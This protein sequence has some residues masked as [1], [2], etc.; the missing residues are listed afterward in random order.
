MFSS[1]QSTS[2]YC[3]LTKDSRTFES[4][5]WRAWDLQF[6][7]APEPLE[8]LQVIKRK[9]ATSK[10][11]LPELS[12]VLLQQPTHTALEC[13]SNFSVFTF[14]RT[15]VHVTFSLCFTRTRVSCIFAQISWLAIVSHRTAFLTRRSEKALETSQSVLCFIFYLFLQMTR[16]RESGCW[17]LDRLSLIR[18]ASLF[19]ASSKCNT[20]NFFN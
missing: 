5:L 7:K 17:R 6:S 18:W 8:T 9:L 3:L 13:P 14:S 4:E 15:Q 11:R 16:G 10:P 1:K 12:S 2:C 19:F 20:Q